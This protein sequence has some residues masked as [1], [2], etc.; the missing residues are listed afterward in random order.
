MFEDGRQPKYTLR[1]N[2]G[3]EFVNNKVGQ[4]LREMR[5]HHIASHNETKTN[6][7][8]R[9]TKTINQKLIRYVMKKKQKKKYVDVLQDVMKSYNNTI[10]RYLRDTPN[11]IHKKNESGSRFCQYLIR[12]P[13]PSRNLKSGRR[14]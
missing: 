8:E 1:T 5:I 14:A 13:K 3:R 2:K 9:V 12:K 10:H 11:S 4:L 7:A 6:Y